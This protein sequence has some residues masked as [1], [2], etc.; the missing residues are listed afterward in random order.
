VRVLQITTH[1]NI[2]GIS[3]YILSLSKAL[4]DEGLEVA[5]ASSGGELEGEFRDL[6]VSHK[7]IG[8]MTKFEFGPKVLMSIP[9]IVRF[10]RKEKIDVIHAHTRVSQVAAC[11]ASLISGVPFVSTC[12]GYFKKRARGVL[13]T[14]G[15]KV[16]AISA[17]VERHLIDDLGVKKDRVKL[18]YSGVDASKFSV[19]YSSE[20]IE[21]TKIS[22]GISGKSVVGT[23]GRLSPVKGQRFFIEAMPE[24][25]KIKPDA[26]GLVV[27]SGPEE[28]ALKDK[29]RALGVEGLIK[30]IDSVSAF[31]TDSLTDTRKILAAM[32]VFVFPSVKE[33]LG[34]ALLE[35]LACGKACVA[36]R[37][38]GIEDIITDHETGLLTG[39]GDVSAISKSIL[40]LLSDKSL[41]AR[42]GDNGRRMV[43]EK[44][45]L[46]RMARE[47]IQVY[48]GLVN[49]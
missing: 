9:S 45:A 22:L 14:W 4:K 38:G 41:R 25:M 32:D 30:F 1:L 31:G 12:H 24:V 3:N 29:V 5:L 11:L 15:R 48:E 39:S 27:G 35:A 42:M 28:A 49:S 21:A 7:A 44:F 47:I 2:G 19:Q 17:A 16:I 18:I 10:I 23:I 13:D 20:E 8:I 40:E 34:I 36:S 6:G 33:G 43:Q 26:V 46:K 37:V